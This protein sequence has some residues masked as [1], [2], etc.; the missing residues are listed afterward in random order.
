MDIKDQN[1]G[2]Q[3][4]Q[5][6]AINIK[7]LCALLPAILGIIFSQGVSH[8]HGQSS[9]LELKL[10]CTRMRIDSRIDLARSQ[11]NNK[12]QNFG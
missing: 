10:N 11:R 3:R 2:Q 6:A 9:I 7:Q 12:D 1:F 4:F 5:D 8:L